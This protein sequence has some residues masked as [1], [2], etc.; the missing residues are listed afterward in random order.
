MPMADDHTPDHGHEHEHGHDEETHEDPRSRVRAIQ[1]LLVE[2][3]IVSMDAIDEAIAAYE[4]EIGPE[5]GARVVAR[6]WTDPAFKERLVA[7]PMDAIDAFDFDV[8]TQHIEVKENTDD[9]LNVVVCTLCSCYPWSF[10]G[11]RRRGTRRRRTARGLSASPA[12][13]SRSSASR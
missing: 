6:A 5:N 2:D 8:G 11:C 1:S 12:P 10:L 13:C 9:V 7:D 3:G 4:R